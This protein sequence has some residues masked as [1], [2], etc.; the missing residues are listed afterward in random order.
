MNENHFNFDD[1]TLSDAE[2]YQSLLVFVNGCAN[3]IRNSALALRTYQEFL[4]DETGQSQAARDFLEKSQRLA[5]NLRDGAE[6]IL[7][8]AADT[9][10]QERID[11]NPIVKSV[12]ERAR[13][14][15]TSPLE[16]NLDAGKKVMVNANVYQLQDAFFDAVTLV[17][18]AAEKLGQ[19]TILSVK[20]ISLTANQLGLMG[21][22]CDEGD[23]VAVNVKI[24][25]MANDSQMVASHQLVDNAR[26]DDLLEQLVFWTGTAMLHNGETIT[27]PENPTRNISFL[28]PQTQ[29][30]IDIQESGDEWKGHETILLVDDEDMIWDVIIDML[31]ELGYLVILAENGQEAIDIYKGNPGGIDLVLMDMVMP[32]MNA[33]EA[34]PLLKEIDPKVKV[35]LSSGFVSQEDAKDVL[36]AGAKGFLRKP[37]RLAELAKA[38]RNILDNKPQR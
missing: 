34:F 8:R 18:N 24:A 23:F 16:V 12:A 33:R 4:E 6:F 36:E 17:A 26:R 9:S 32:V 2:K 19:G 25:S 22:N 27:D 14:I 11:L 37:Y 20:R 28:F 38:I 1:P 31:S 5:D 30:L 13:K 21:S 3:L 35:L 15:M 10:D 7:E 29:E